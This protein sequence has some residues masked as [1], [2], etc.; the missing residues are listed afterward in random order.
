MSSSRIADDLAGL[1]DLGR[2][3]TIKTRVVKTTDDDES[4][5]NQRALAVMEEYDPLSTQA[6]YGTQAPVHENGENCPLCYYKDPGKN[7]AG[8]S[9]MSKFFDWLEKMCNSSRN[10][11][12]K[13][14]LASA[15]KRYLKGQNEF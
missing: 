7:L 8:E 2:T 6:I 11:I 15:T 5:G 1:M 13:T 10:T 3:I 14:I 4:I 9:I 12:E